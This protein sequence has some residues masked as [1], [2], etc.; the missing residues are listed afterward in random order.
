MPLPLACIM[1]IALSVCAAFGV[2]EPCSRFYPS[3][4]TTT[5]TLSVSPVYPEGRRAPAGNHRA[6]PEDNS[7]LPSANP[8]QIEG[9]WETTGASGIDGIFLTIV[10]G[11]NWQ[12]INIRVY[13]RNAGK[14]T[15]GYFATKEKATAQSYN[16]QDDHSFTL[17]DGSRLRIHFVD[18]T[19]LKPFDLDLAFSSSSH[20][21]SGSWPRSGQPPDVTLRRPEP[22]PGVTA[23]PFVGD[24]TGASNKPYLAPGSLHIRQSSDG[25]LSAWLDRVIG[26]I[27]RRNGELLLVHSAAPLDLDLE[28]PGETGPSYRY[29]GTLSGDGQTITGEWPENGGGGLNAPDQFRKTPME[30]N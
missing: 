21:W 18:S 28:R 25:T 1:L 7:T 26:S 29:H 8:E 3:Q 30:S 17:F 5:Q 2:R 4:N 6:A 11:R 10:T 27:D 20:E 15:W 23:N 9:P 19:D 16:L 14:E 12:I 24:W 22:K 13:H